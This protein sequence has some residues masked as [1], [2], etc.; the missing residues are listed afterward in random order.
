MRCFSF[1]LIGRGTTSTKERVPRPDERKI[2]PVYIIIFSACFNG[3]SRFIQ[4]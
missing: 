1:D 4:S 2:I 3:S